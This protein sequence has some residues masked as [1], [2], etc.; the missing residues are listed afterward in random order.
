MK[1]IFLFLILTPLLSAC[2]TSNPQGTVLKADRTD[3]SDWS[4][5]MAIES[6]CPL[7]DTLGLQLSVARKSIIGTERLFFL[8]YKTRLVYAFTPQGEYLFTVGGLG[9]AVNEYVD[10]TDMAF[11]PDETE[12]HLLDETGIKVYDA[13]TGQFIRKRE[14]G[15]IDAS[16]VKGFLPYDEGSYLLFTPEDDYSIN[17]IDNENRATPL[18]KRGG[19]QMIYNRFSVVGGQPVVLPDYGRFTIDQETGGRLSARYTID[20]GESTFPTS[21]IPKDFNAFMKADDGEDYFKFICDYYENG[22]AVYASLVGPSQTYY[23][24]LY[25][26]IVGQL[27]VGPRDKATNIVFIGMDD[28]FAYGLA[29]VDY[30]TEDSPYY[31]LFSEY[32]EENMQNPLVV[33]MKLFP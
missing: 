5:L 12:L 13:G 18:R 24:L 33:K 2:S 22:K 4:A 25:D 20:L 21:Q 29:Y 19:Y 27:Y 9:R 8:D 28:D 15:S 26:K 16:S 7:G 32:R 10:V 30:M 17:K 3:Y 23:D 14:L 31:D 1:K 11:S 6:I